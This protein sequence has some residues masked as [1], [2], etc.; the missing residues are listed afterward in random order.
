MTPKLEQ[1]SK[2]EAGLVGVTIGTCFSMSL[3][4][5]LGHV[6]WPL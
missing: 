6:T 5:V 4:S 2:R 1:V 3:P